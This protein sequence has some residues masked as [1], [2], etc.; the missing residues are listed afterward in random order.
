MCS[1]PEG[2]VQWLTPVDRRLTGETVSPRVAGYGMGFHTEPAF[3]A[4][5]QLVAAAVDGHLLELDATTG[6]LLNRRTISA[7]VHSIGYTVVLDSWLL[8]TSNGLQLHQRTTRRANA[9]QDTRAGE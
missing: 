2:R 9:N 3:S 5:G 7:V 4:D 1:T 6:T 8:A